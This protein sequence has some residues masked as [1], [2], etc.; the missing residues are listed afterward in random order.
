MD[1]FEPRTRIGRAVLSKPGRMAIVTT[2]LVALVALLLGSSASWAE[3]IGVFCVFVPVILWQHRRW[4]YA[5]R[6]ALEK[7]DRKVQSPVSRCPSV[8]TLAWIDDNAHCHRRD[9]WYCLRDHAY[10]DV[11]KV[12]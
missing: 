5:Y 8:L 10:R 7:R 6:N 11:A 1:I 4:A 3:R 9:Y 12:S 2:M